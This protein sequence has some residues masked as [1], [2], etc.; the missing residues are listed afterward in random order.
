MICLCP[1]TYFATGPSGDKQSSKGLSHRTN[2]LCFQDYA[3]VL[4]QQTSGLG[5]NRSFRTDGQ[6][7]LTYFQDRSSLSYLYLKRIVCPDKISTL[8]TLV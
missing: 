1:K 7:V 4:D 6:T 3:R 8:P 2:T 5:Q